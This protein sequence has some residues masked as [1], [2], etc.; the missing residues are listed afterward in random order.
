MVKANEKIDLLGHEDLE[1]GVFHRFFLTVHISGWIL[2]Y[3]IYTPTT[4][5]YYTTPTWA[6]IYNAYLAL[7]GALIT[8][9]IARPIHLRIIDLMGLNLTSFWINLGAGIVIGLGWSW[10]ITSLPNLFDFRSDLNL[11]TP[12]AAKFIVYESVIII[13]VLLFLGYS[14][15]Y[16]KSRNL[17]IEQRLRYELALKQRELISKATYLQQKNDLISSLKKELEYKL[18][19]LNNDE[20]KRSITSVVASMND[21][22]RSE[23]DWEEFEKQFATVYHGFFMNLSKQ[24]PNLT[25]TDLKMC[26]YQKMNLNTKEIA[27]LTGLSVRAVENRR[28][29]MRKK[30]NLPKGVNLTPFLNEIAGDNSL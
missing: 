6:I 29:R 27:Q 9:F 5:A 30:M 25:S 16:E 20:D 4:F 21:A 13:W 19:L 17:R 23:E 1:A 14:F 2:F 3:V 11:N 12:A 24:F 28:Y 8:F 10:M 15:L 22:I 18:S 7:T 26:A